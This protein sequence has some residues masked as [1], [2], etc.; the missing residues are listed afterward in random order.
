[1]YRRVNLILIHVNYIIRNLCPITA[2][3]SCKLILLLTHFVLLANYAFLL[4]LSYFVMTSREGIVIHMRGPKETVGRRRFFAT[5]HVLAI[6]TGVSLFQNHC[7]YLLADRKGSR[8][9]R[10]RNLLNL[11]LLFIKLIIANMFK[12]YQVCVIKS[13]INEAVNTA[14]A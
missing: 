4:H 5:Y 14:F 1:M 3:L 2:I 6:L 11:L 9:K 12:Y 7:C 10:H 13:V 8:Y